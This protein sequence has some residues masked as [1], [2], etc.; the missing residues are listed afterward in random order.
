MTFLLVKP[1]YVR[2]GL[3]QLIKTHFHHYVSS[4]I[5][6]TRNDRGS[7]SHV[8]DDFMTHHD[9]IG[10]FYCYNFDLSAYKRATIKGKSE[11]LL[12]CQMCVW[13]KKCKMMV[14]SS[15]N[16][17]TLHFPFNQITAS[18]FQ[19]ITQKRHW[20]DLST[21]KK[22]LL[23]EIIV[24]CKNNSTEH[25]VIMLVFFFINRGTFNWFRCV[26]YEIREK[27]ERTSM[28]NWMKHIVFI[29]LS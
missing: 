19:F 16:L 18:F 3:N 25:I 6:I 12:S 22:K 11:S 1:W 4:L 2:K 13:L 15:L 27:E 29:C 7:V 17:S 10:W 14:G 21:E 5:V 20:S 26:L 8:D 9:W 28:F 23:V 24:I